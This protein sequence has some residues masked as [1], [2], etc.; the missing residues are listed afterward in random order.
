MNPSGEP[1]KPAASRPRRTTARNP[2]CGEGRRAWN[3]EHV[4][5]PNYNIAPSGR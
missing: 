4:F 1:T 2:R 5:H 3:P